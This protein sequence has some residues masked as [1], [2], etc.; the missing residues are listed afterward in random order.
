MSQNNGYST[1][2]WI[3]LEDLD[4]S[5]AS[6]MRVRRDPDAVQ[7][8]SEAIT[9]LPPILVARDQQ[10]KHWTI[11]GAHRHEGAKLAGKTKVRC[12]VCN[13]ADY[14]EAFAAACHANEENR[15]V[16]VTNADKRFRVEV[17]LRHEEMSKWSARRIAEACGVDNSTVSKVRQLLESNSSTP[18][19]GKDGKTRKPRSSRGSGTRKTKKPVGEPVRSAGAKDEGPKPEEPEPT[20]ASEETDGSIDPNDQTEIEDLEPDDGDHE[21]DDPEEFDMGMAWRKVEDFLE[22]YIE[23]WS[24]GHRMVFA[25]RLRSHADLILKGCPN[26]RDRSHE[27]FV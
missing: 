25:M 12:R 18:T 11:D 1:E 7:E 15:A 13:V 8:Y 23:D 17:A 9:K 10:G 22:C 19:V 24:E 26:V 21:E 6:E 2:V 4:P 14:T 27:V 5:P 20:P 16:R 3:D